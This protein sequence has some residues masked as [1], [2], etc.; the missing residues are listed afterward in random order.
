M[1]KKILFCLTFVAVTLLSA[2]GI[3]EE[4]EQAKAT[5]KQL[6]TTLTTQEAHYN[7]L[8]ENISDI[9][10][11]FEADLL[12]VP[13]TGRFADGEGLI[14]DNLTERNELISHL[15]ESN[16]AVIDSQ[17][18]L[19]HIIKRNGADV[20]NRQLALVSQSLDIILGNYSS[21]EVYTT[22]NELQVEEFYGNLPTDDLDSKLSI[23]E[24]TYGSIEQVSE[25]A[26][27]NIEYSLSLVETFLSEAPQNKERGQ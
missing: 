2:C 20:D 13:E 23:L 12:A 15:T 27:A 11:A 25:E 19:K 1:S 3:T 10:T 14:F 21:L 26:I 16:Q 24:R 17:K 4:L 7:N 8:I 22:L 18:E 9:P 5:V 6:K